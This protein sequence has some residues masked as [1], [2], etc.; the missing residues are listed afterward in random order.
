ME[1]EIVRGQKKEVLKLPLAKFPVQG[2]VFALNKRPI[3]KGIRVD[4]LS[5][6][7]RD[8]TLG[9]DP[10]TALPQGGVVIR[11]IAEGSPAYEKGLKPNQVISKVN[12]KTI[13][14]PDE[15]EREVERASFPVRLSMF[16]GQEVTFDSADKSEKSNKKAD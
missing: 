10:L 6:L 5:T 1:T 2:E 14:S 7:T 3:W 15:F 16:Q 8:Q 4:H 11:E 12:D 13:Y 9:L